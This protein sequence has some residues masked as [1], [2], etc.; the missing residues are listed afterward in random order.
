LAFDVL[1]ELGFSAA[2]RL[3]GG[4]LQAARQA[5]PREFPQR[6]C[7]DDDGQHNAWLTY[8]NLTN[9]NGHSPE[10]R[11]RGDMTSTANSPS[12]PRDTILK[13][14]ETRNC[15]ATIRGAGLARC[16]P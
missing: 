15:F 13:Q 5:T 4:L 2:F 6:T 8:I 16:E 10:A 11:G 3:L 1:G 7:D 9:C 14:I 12:P